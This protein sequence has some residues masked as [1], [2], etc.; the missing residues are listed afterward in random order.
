MKIFKGDELLRLI[1]E[2]AK[3]ISYT[4]PGGARQTLHKPHEV[5][6][7]VHAAPFGRISLQDL[8]GAGKISRILWIPIK[9]TAPYNKAEEID[10]VK[11][12]IIEDRKAAGWGEPYQAQEIGSGQ[13]VHWMLYRADMITPDSIIMTA[14][15]WVGGLLQ[16]YCGEGVELGLDLMAE[17][18]ITA[19]LQEGQETRYITAEQIKTAKR[20]LQMEPEDGNI[21]AWLEERGYEYTLHAGQTLDVITIQGKKP[22]TIYYDRT[23]RE[24]GLKDPTDPAMSWG[25]W[26]QRHAKDQQAAAQER[27]EK[28]AYEHWA[29]D[30]PA[31]G[32]LRVL[33][34][35]Y[36]RGQL[37]PVLT[38]AELRHRERVPKEFVPTGIV[39]F[40]RRSQG[41]PKGDVT[42]ITA[43]TS[44]GKTQLINQV[45]ANLLVTTPCRI[46]EYNG[47]LP[48]D[49]VADHLERTIAGKYRVQH[50]ASRIWEITAEQADLIW[51]AI[52]DRYMLYPNRLGTS[53]AVIEDHL[54]QCIM[55][56]G[57]DLAIFDDQIMLDMNIAPFQQYRDEDARAVALI[58]RL[59]L[60]A[61]HYGLAVILVCHPRKDSTLGKRAPLLAQKEDILGS[62]KQISLAATVLVYHRVWERE[63][64]P[65]FKM[66]EAS[67]LMIKETDPIRRIACDGILQVA[68]DRY[69]EGSKSYLIPLMYEAG[70]GR[71]YSFGQ[72]QL[73][74]DDLWAEYDA[75]EKARLENL[76]SSGKPL[77][78]EVKQTQREQCKATIDQITLGPNPFLQGKEAG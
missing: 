41:F 10:Q 39:D 24:A 26:K 55:G 13:E 27:A 72:T 68:K 77:P 23:R 62:V 28:A 50:P 38:G 60:I 43:K 3:G 30:R 51:D 76:I 71:L 48:A 1:T 7:A 29:K 57:V 54:I 52:G 8:D 34:E 9:V 11:K 12:Q 64:E 78:P 36:P 16:A 46:W 25:E 20:A 14:L 37:Y 49:D 59:K 75:A 33:S 47:E 35:P 18:P 45:K 53:Y 5:I 21:T 15:D 66:A 44:D 31:P 69:G 73:P 65:W 63:M 4:P 56:G 17:Y 42:I 6:E 19:E 32:E 58:R 74:L 61:E 22:V 70:S 2:S 67:G 40:D